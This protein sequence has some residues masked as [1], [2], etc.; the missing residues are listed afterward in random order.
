MIK[1]IFNKVQILNLIK[2]VINHPPLSKPKMWILS[3]FFMLFSPNVRSTLTSI[4]V[5][6][7]KTVNVLK[8][9]FNYSNKSVT[10]CPRLTLQVSFYF[11]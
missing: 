3:P 7:Q 10:L 1:T 4:P 6:L 9:T 2:Y 5:L 8:G 11:S